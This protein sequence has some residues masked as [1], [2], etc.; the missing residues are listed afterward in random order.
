MQQNAPRLHGGQRRL[1]CLTPFNRS[2]CARRFSCAAVASSG[3]RL[4][5]AVAFGKRPGEGRPT[6]GARC[7]R[8][9]AV[10]VAAWQRAPANPG[11]NGATICVSGRRGHALRASARQRPRE[12]CWIVYTKAWAACQGMCRR[13]RTEPG[14]RAKGARAAKGWRGCTGPCRRWGGQLAACPRGRPGHWE[15]HAPRPQRRR[16]HDETS[17]GTAALMRWGAAAE[18]SQLVEGLE[19]A[20]QVLAVRRP[21]MVRARGHAGW[22]AARVCG[23]RGRPLCAPLQHRASAGGARG[24]RGALL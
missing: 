16:R 23:R 11:N 17:D 19:C 22:G 4:E 6:T 2:S 20:T 21:L 24:V 9:R 7:A 8:G 5:G 1:C 3:C 12:E 15:P 10:A 13:A 14:R 18:A